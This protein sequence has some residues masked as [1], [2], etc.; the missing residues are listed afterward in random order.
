VWSV[1]GRRRVLD[2]SLHREQLEE[3]LATAAIASVRRSGL[4]WLAEDHLHGH[5]AS[6]GSKSADYVIRKLRQMVRRSVLKS[7]SDV[8][9]ALDDGHKLWAETY[10][11]ETVG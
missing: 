11:V 2:A 8:A 5:F 10:F 1:A 9:A 7:S 6:D 4:L 3:L